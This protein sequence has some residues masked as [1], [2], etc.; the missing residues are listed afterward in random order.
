M[1]ST[2]TSGFFMLP[3]LLFVP[4]LALSLASAQTGIDFSNAPGYADLQLCGRAS[5]SAL[6]EGQLCST[7]ACIC[8]SDNCVCG[9]DSG[10][11]AKAEAVIHAYCANLGLGGAA[12][13]GGSSDNG[14]SLPSSSSTST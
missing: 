8:D 1:R 9:T 3:I 11:Q 12:S 14:A 5:L 13:N 10:Q 4:V 7:N 6:A 2:L